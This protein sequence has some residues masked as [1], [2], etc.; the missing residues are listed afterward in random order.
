MFSGDDLLPAQLRAALA[1]RRKRAVA[2]AAR[3]P[4]A[5]LLPLLCRERGYDI[6]FSRRTRN[7]TSHQGQI[8]FPGGTREPGDANLLAT[9]LREAEE[10]IGLRPGD[11]TVIGELDD[12]ITTT[13]NY[14]ITP[15]VVSVP[16]PYRFRIQRAEIEELIY[17][18]LETLRDARCQRPETEEI[19][20]RATAVTSYLYRGDIIWGATARILTQFLDIMSR[21][22]AGDGEAV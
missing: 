5:V 17:V 3:V 7:L 18:P 13:S 11:V 1:G 21:L 16:W 12:C 22:P 2:D 8:S 14:I 20:G 6:L 9:A 10:E 19:D 15:F 4:S